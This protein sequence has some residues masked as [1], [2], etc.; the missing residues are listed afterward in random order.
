MTNP[1]IDPADRAEPHAD[2]FNDPRAQITR[3]GVLIGMAVIL[4]GVIGAAASIYGRRTRLQQTTQFWGEETILALQLGERMELQP[5][6]G[7]DFP[8][9]NLSGMP[10]LG[11]LRRTLLD[12]RNFDWDTRCDETV[13]SKVAGQAEPLCITLQITDPTAH[14]VGT[15]RIDLDLVDGWVGHEDVPRAVRISERKRSGVRHFLVTI[16]DMEPL[17]Y[18]DR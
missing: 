8:V 18:D 1:S 14:R 2:K 15:V 17:R 4:F 3:R 7:K 16:M 11:H 9:V 13:Q 5:A 10:G 12:E 6:R